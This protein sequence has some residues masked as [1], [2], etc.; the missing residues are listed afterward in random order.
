MEC[1]LN[2]RE[3]SVIFTFAG[4]LG[5]VQN[6]E[7]MINAFTE[8]PISYECELRIIGG[9]VFLNKIT[10]LVEEKK[11]NRVR[12]YGRK[13][14]NEMKKWFEESDVLVISLK[15]EFDLTIPAKFQAYLAAERPILASI[16][17]DTALLVEKYSLGYTA[18][19]SDI[20][21]ITQAFEK[22]YHSSH[23]QFDYWRN[24]VKK[25]SKEMFD[26]EKIILS[27]E[28]ELIKL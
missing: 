8:L 3:K 12:V 4:N 11:E 24:N 17:G 27:I 15:P 28:D 14:R 9:G 6:L 10:R 25:L 23:E 18:D 21:S 5:S 7:V 16:R 1:E 22:F 20:K 26:R 2:K 19:P 13:P